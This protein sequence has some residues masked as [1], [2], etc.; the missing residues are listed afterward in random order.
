MI[1]LI[2]EYANKN[3]LS[4]V[5]QRFLRDW[6]RAYAKYDANLKKYNQIPTDFSTVNIWNSNEFEMFDKNLVLSLSY[7]KS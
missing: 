4:I 6:T 2:F 3:N 1:D 5:L 7:L